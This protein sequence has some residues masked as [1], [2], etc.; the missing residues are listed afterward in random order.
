[1]HNPAEW[2]HWISWR[3]QIVAQI[4][5]FLGEGNLIEHQVS[6]FRASTHRLLCWCTQLWPQVHWLMKDWE[7]ITWPVLARGQLRVHQGSKLSASTHLLLWGCTQFGP[8]VM[9][10]MRGLGRDHVTR[11]GLKTNSMTRGQHTYNTYTDIATTR[12]NRPR[13]Q[14]SENYQFTKPQLVC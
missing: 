7:V 1:M 8:L 5:L 3:V 11:V 13:G 14:F 9:C 10:P 4:S 12:L 2:R 6:S